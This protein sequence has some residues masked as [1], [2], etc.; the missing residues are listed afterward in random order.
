MP[1][2]V[3]FHFALIVGIVG[4]IMDVQLMIITYFWD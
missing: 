3:I 2:D 1:I 4:R